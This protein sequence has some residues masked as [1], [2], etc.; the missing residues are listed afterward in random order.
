[1][2]T[3]AVGLMRRHWQG[4]YGLGRSFW[5][6]YVASHIALQWLVRNLDGDM[7]LRVRALIALGYLLLLVLLYVWAGRGVWKA[8]RRQRSAG[9]SFAT[10][11][12]VTVLVHGLC[13]CTTGLTGAEA[14]GEMFAIV[15]GE[16]MRE[17]F[18]L[19]VSDDGKTLALEGGISEGLADAL[20]AAL[21][22]APHVRTLT[23]SSGGGLVDEADKVQRIVTEHALNTRVDGACISA[24][25]GIF[26]AG[27]ERLLGSAGALGFHRVRM[28]GAIA[29]T[30]TDERGATAAFYAYALHGAV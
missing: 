14:L 21:A 25:T 29:R 20:R 27:K 23:L 18:T 30:T 13:L 4:G 26:L 11:A 1:M 7:P 28:V 6:H 19:Q 3:K 24:C 10:L 2:E 22:V 8:A 16:S 5:V 15:G 12:Q 17:P 9:R